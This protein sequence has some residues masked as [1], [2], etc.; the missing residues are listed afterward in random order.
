MNVVCVSIFK[1]TR[2]SGMQR[3]LCLVLLWPEFSEAAGGY[4]WIVHVDESVQLFPRDEIALGYM[5]FCSY[6]SQRFQFF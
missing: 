2:G 5:E 6:C 3:E 4:T 1:F